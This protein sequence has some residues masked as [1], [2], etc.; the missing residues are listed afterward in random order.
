MR[1]AGRQQV[2]DSGAMLANY[3]RVSPVIANGDVGV[4]GAE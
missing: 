4:S 2:D 3:A 1:C